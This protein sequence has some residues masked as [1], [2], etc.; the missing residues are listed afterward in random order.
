MS[1]LQRIHDAFQRALAARERDAVLRLTRAYGE[2]WR[3]IRAELE[4]NLA[5]MDAAR[6]KGETVGPSWVWTDMR[7]RALLAQ[8]EAEIARWAATAAEVAAD[9]QREGVALGLGELEAQMAAQL[10]AG[11]LG[12]FDRLSRDALEDVI[13]FAGDG[14]P[15]ARLFDEL[16]PQARHRLT[17]ALATGLAVGENPRRVA[18]EMASRAAGLTLARALTIARTEMLRAYREAAHRG[19]LANRDVLRG[20]RWAASLSVRTCA[21]C[22]AMHGTLHTLDER[23]EDH[24]NGRCTAVY[25][26]KSW[27]DLG[28][29]GVPETTP[30]LPDA[31]TWLRSLTEDEQARI[32]G[33]EAARL[34]RDGV[35]PLAAFSERRYD[36]V[37]GAIRVQ[38]PL[39]RIL[40][41]YG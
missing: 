27:G 12:A 21:S 32:M 24:P 10:P 8:A 40:D 3:F 23:L 5:R 13:G 16:G 15:L 25:I 34:W 30:D 14:G 28:I 20:W 33:R 11:A 31:E 29:D 6:E 37:W 2:I 26:T 1:E 7:L 4:A 36:P 35:I 18:V 19:A 38:K 9:M 41:S 39:K 22:L 17:R